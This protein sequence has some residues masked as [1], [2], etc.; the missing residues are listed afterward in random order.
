VGA[1]APRRVDTKAFATP[2][3]LSILDCGRSVRTGVV[4]RAKG[5]KVVVRYRA[6]TT[7]TT[8]PAAAAAAASVS[9]ALMFTNNNLPAVLCELLDRRQHTHTEK[10]PNRVR[11]RGGHVYCRTV[12]MNK[13]WSEAS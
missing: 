10:R 8:A 9:A 5:K 3:H 6:T 11:T 12:M 4:S 13:E 7:A 2:R 1:A